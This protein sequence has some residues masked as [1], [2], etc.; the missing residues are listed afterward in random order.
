MV[1]QN[2]LYPTN[3][4]VSTSNLLLKAFHPPTLTPTPLPLPCRLPQ[5]R[6][7]NLVYLDSRNTGFPQQSFRKQI[8]DTEITFS[9]E[10]YNCCVRQETSEQPQTIPCPDWKEDPGDSWKM[11]PTR[12]C[13]RPRKTVS[14]FKCR[15]WRA[16]PRNATAYAYT[17]PGP[18]LRF[19]GYPQPCSSPNSLPADKDLTFSARDAARLTINTCGQLPLSG[20][21][22]DGQDGA[23]EWAW[24]TGASLIPPVHDRR[25]EGRDWL[26]RDK[27]RVEM[28]TGT[29]KQPAR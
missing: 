8:I 15:R 26:I 29:G 19:L 11:I 23:G 10:D 2:K 12:T 24:S 3:E 25:L 22:G 21:S 18:R 17:I 20:L 4:Q 27:G 14:H 6:P 28:G 13:R 5:P 1:T 9:L 7:G 16:L